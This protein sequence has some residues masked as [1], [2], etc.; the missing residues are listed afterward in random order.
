MKK[1]ISRRFIVS[2]L[3]AVMAVGLL[4]GCGSSGKSDTIEIGLATP[5]TGASAQD[6]QAIENG[7]ELA[8]KQANDAGGI[9]G[10]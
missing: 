5:L 7:V 3:T 2:G 9:D 1:R 6:G 8:V 10:K 4:T